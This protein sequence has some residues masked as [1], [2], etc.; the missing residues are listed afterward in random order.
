MS[1]FYVSPA[2]ENHFVFELD[3]YILESS[4]KMGGNN[5][6][7]TGQ[8]IGGEYGGGDDDFNHDWE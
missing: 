5:M 2:I 8:E 1:N 4:S 3:G 6:G 7:S